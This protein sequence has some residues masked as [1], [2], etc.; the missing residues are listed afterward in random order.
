MESN[1]S[2]QL[3]DIIEI[4]ASQ[5]PELHQQQFF[6]KYIDN[7]KISLDNGVQKTVTLNI[8]PNGELYEES[9]ETITIL[10]R[11]ESPS[12]IEQN[13]Y[14][15]GKWLS[16]YFRGTFPIIINSL[17]TN[18]ENDMIELKTYPNNDIIYIDFE[19][20]GI[21]EA[22]NIEKIL[23]IDE[24]DIKGVQQREL[25]I[26][27][28]LIGKTEGD[29]DIQ[30]IDQ[31][32]DDTV[33]DYR[34]G[35]KDIILE[36][37]AIEMG[38]ELDS[39]TQEIK[40]EEQQFR[41]S[42]NKQLDD[43]LDDILS[44]IPNTK[45][46]EA[47]MD[48][49]N[50]EIERFR[51][52]REKFSNFDN[53]NSVKDVKYY[54]DAHPLV[55]N[56]KTLEH[57]LAWILPVTTCR[58]EI[59]D[60]DTGDNP[61]LTEKTLLEFL[62][63]ISQLNNQWMS[64]QIGHDEDK[65][66][67]WIKKLYEIFEPYSRV[68]NN[69]DDI[70]ANNSL[71]LSETPVNNETVVLID[72]TNSLE[73][74]GINRNILSTK[75]YDDIILNRSHQVLK[76]EYD[77]NSITRYQVNVKENDPL[78][79][80]AIVTLPNSYTA[81][82]NIRLPYTNIL[83]Q[84][85]LNQMVKYNHRI[86]RPRKIINTTIIDNRTSQGESIY[87]DGLD[88]NNIHHFVP[89]TY[90][91]SLEQ[92][93]Q[94][95][96]NNF[97]IKALP[98]KHDVLTDIKQDA[99]NI[100][101]FTSLIERLQPYLIMPDTM[102][103]DDIE[104]I[105]S[106][107]NISIQ[108]YKLTIK[109]YQAKI[110][111]DKTVSSSIEERGLI[112]TIT[113]EYSGD[114]L[115]D[116]YKIINS[117]YTSSELFSRILAVDDGRVY[118]DLLKN[119]ITQ[120]VISD[121]IGKLD[122]KYSSAK[123]E[124]VSEEAT[125]ERVQEAVAID[126]IS[127][128]SKSVTISE[129]DMVKEEQDGEDKSIEDMSTEDNSIEDEMDSGEKTTTNCRKYVFSK[130]YLDK[131]EIQED[132]DRE[133]YFDRQYDKTPYPI[134]DEY[135]EERQS[136]SAEDFYIFLYKN[137][138][139]NIGLDEESAKRDARSMIDQKR[140]IID[141]DYALLESTGE[142]YI[143]SSGKW[144]IDK[145]VTFERFL[146]T[147]K[148]FCNIQKNCVELD[149][150][151][152]D[153]V[154][155]KKLM[156]QQEI[157]QALR[158]FDNK[159]E[160]S[161]EKIRTHLAESLKN[162]E[163]YL[164]KLRRIFKHDTEIYNSRFYKI[165]M[166]LT[167]A[168]IIVSPYDGLRNR[169]LEIKDFSKRQLYIIKFCKFF[170]R[171]P[172]L[173]NTSGGSTQT[174]DIHW[175][176]CIKTSNK[177]IPAFLLRL[178]EVF[179]NKGDYQMEVDTI[180]A[181]Q[182]T[183]SD[184][185][186]NWVDKY[187]GYTI[188]SI[189]FNNEEGFDSQGYRLQSRE[190]IE[191][192]YAFNSN[193]NSKSNS[194]LSVQDDKPD[195]KTVN[196]K[197]INII[198][199][200]GGFIGIDLSK[201]REFI[202]N[203]VVEVNR[204]SLPPRENYERLLKKAEGREKRMLPYNDALNTNLI[205]ISLVFILVAIQTNIP[206]FSTKRVFPGC[207]KSFTGYPLE[208]DVDKSGMIYLACV[209]NKIKSNI[210]P[211][212]S[213]I[214]TSQLTIAKKMEAIIDKYVVANRDIKRLVAAKLD[215]L[216]TNPDEKIDKA[217]AIN[218]WS[219]FLPPLNPYE[220]DSTLTQPIEKI[221]GYLKT[222]IARNKSD[223]AKNTI[224]A[225]IK[226]LS[227]DVYR[228]IES[229]VEKNKPI[230]SNNSGEPFLENSCCDSENNVV[231]DYFIENDRSI[232]QTLD[233]I[234][235]YSGTL[236]YLNR[237]SRAA[238]VFYPLPTK[239]L[240]QRDLDSDGFTENIIYSGFIYYCRYYSQDE[241]EIESGIDDTDLIKSICGEPLKNID[242]SKPI[243]EIIEIYR[244]EGRNY[245]NYD[246][247]NLLV[248]IS[249]RN[250]VPLDLTK[251]APNNETVLKR[252][253]ELDIYKSMMDDKFVELLSSV[254]DNSDKQSS[255][256]VQELNDN[257]RELKNYLSREIKNIRLNTNTFLNRNSK[258]SRRDIERI[259]GF[260]D[261]IIGLDGE[262]ES[263]VA[264]N[265]WIK[266][267]KNA[268]SSLVSVFP[269]MIV[270]RVDTRN[271]GQSRHWN[272]SGI[273]NQDITY[274]MSEYYEGL[275]KFYD[276]KNL[277]VLLQYL[278]KQL[279]PITIFIHDM[280]ASIFDKT[281]VLNMLVYMFFHA[282]DKYLHTI[283]DDLTRQELYGDGELDL[284]GDLDKSINILT[285]DFII[286]ILDINISNIK[287]LDYNNRKIV[288]KIL[289]SREIEKTVITDGLKGLNDEEREIANIFKNNKL[290]D[291]NIGL[292]KGLT[293]Y[294]KENYDAERERLEQQAIQDKKMGDKGIVTEMNREIYRLD[295]EYEEQLQEDIDR[296]NYDM[297]MIPDDGDFDPDD[298]GGDNDEYANY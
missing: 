78:Y 130:K 85:E 106:I 268:I 260:F 186:N 74:Y 119:S 249:R 203:N 281:L 17:V 25:G 155:G 239:S 238:T 228:T 199:A 107:L 38:D 90:N 193:S 269:N 231:I 270:N 212:S 274:F 200:V 222:N 165:A 37:D 3:G 218:A 223:M 9:I 289:K 50:L 171:T 132:N 128:S 73:N 108:D 209:A 141:G 163:I 111:K 295:Q 23:L 137:L 154:E 61:Y 47:T 30:G 110:A 139:K 271:I 124:E 288:D 236:D 201:Q 189:E 123:K 229:V 16:I 255:E 224:I 276:D 67:V 46:N 167:G 91:R 88:K 293:Q 102:S 190:I 125:E 240:K 138:Q 89:E 87:R 153:K 15:I 66:R 129:P 45:R 116:Q 248:Q 214:K 133:I 5:N 185:G 86:F 191:Q 93:Q 95:I 71:Y 242:Y 83:S 292:Q 181:K 161:I 29:R 179:I 81:Y 79:L 162:S 103:H 259:N 62:T 205:I 65:Y 227:L 149:N 13:G 247:E 195:I 63:S 220:I 166:Q 77:M 113:G 28:E 27:P 257:V 183:I 142:I 204:K 55:T 48:L 43:L 254:L 264:I 243:G 127:S 21:P 12:Y 96:L 8:K 2:L 146:Q 230:L 122:K 277:S 41:Y 221:D 94:D 265:Y 267:L 145:T 215:Y 51:Q 180:C 114:R 92:E 213:I 100:Y 258:M 105:K 98:I 196:G 18:V 241:T 164:E 118:L 82:S 253:L 54:G 20:K 278:S 285:S 290:G 208:G 147:N 151:C 219:T 188:K 101:N 59:I 150:R 160:S 64:N 168:D 99:I 109:K 14:T 56:M 152:V 202:V 40:V 34:E 279:L 263:S 58:K 297:G 234:R 144:V 1:I 298:V 294:V 170:T 35:L 273:H 97:L 280:T 296:D 131:D 22:L 104:F 33:Y 70:A 11:A 112:D 84:A 143:R 75:K 10:S 235:V 57:N 157:S 173:K 237:L 262:L 256:E 169:I 60:E 80:K 225:K 275:S 174:E 121:L 49:V 246:F 148:I 140:I 177:L 233:I 251:S 172:I 211:W 206:S 6:I 159:Y 244:R 156:Q 272:L 44:N 53:I 26:D 216:V 284:D 31:D 194:N 7:E 245:S 32:D 19:Y 217:V 52:L 115:L 197:I 261:K 198:N 135:R 291:W 136:M 287:I 252:L 210:E 126:N 24:V 178:A 184:D 283:D 39:I 36:A 192:D 207:I 134:I 175:L 158:G 250:I 226:Y 72:N 286:A 120:I 282:I 266:Y 176:Y 117:T 69:G 187:S 42:I 182:G 68:E 4:E 76:T 232:G